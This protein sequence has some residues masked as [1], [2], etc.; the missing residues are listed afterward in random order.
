MRK[1]KIQMQNDKFNGNIEYENA[2]NLAK[3]SRTFKW[4]SY[5]KELS[6]KF[7][8]IKSVLPLQREIIN[9]VLSHREVFAC[10]QK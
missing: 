9:A 4:E 7:F 5:I 2:N 1:L 3:W 8:A 6:L 10:I